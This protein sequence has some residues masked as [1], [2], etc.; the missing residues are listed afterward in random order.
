MA[1]WP[2]PRQSVRSRAGRAPARAG[3]PCRS[4]AGDG[5]SARAGGAPPRGIRSRNRHCCPSHSP[6]SAP[7][8]ATI[9]RSRRTLATIEAAAIDSERPSP[10]TTHCTAQGS[11]GGW[12]PSTRT[13]SGGEGRR[14]TARH[15]ASSAARRMFSRSISATE[16][17]PDRDFGAA[18]QHAAPGMLSA[19]VRRSASWNHRA[20]RPAGVAR[21]SE[22]PRRR[23][24]PGPRVGRAPPR[25]PP[26][27]AHRRAFPAKSS[28]RTLINKRQGV[29]P[30]VTRASLS[31]AVRWL[32]RLRTFGE[33]GAVG[34]ADRMQRA[35]RRLMV[36]QQPDEPAVGEI[37]FHQILRT[38]QDT[39]ASTRD[40]ASQHRVVDLQPAVDRHLRLPV[41]PIETP[42]H[43]ALSYC[44]VMQCAY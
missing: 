17:A 43:A 35:A 26:R 7:P 20:A 12:L 15:I 34:R 29:G 22:I 31:W 41:R 14:A 18:R 19:A 16:A 21:R 2:K 39:C 11:G 9:A 6:G 44:P 23:R 38:K 33:R 10:P 13:R 24:R 32:T 37:I 3:P 30:I 28:A 27:P 5:G 8:A 1:G 42:A 25:P 36:R 40:I 4:S